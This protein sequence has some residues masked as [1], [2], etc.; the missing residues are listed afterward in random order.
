MDLE[1]GDEQAGDEQ[2]PVVEFQEGE[3]DSDGEDTLDV[4]S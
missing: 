2:I 1:V 4:T 3:G